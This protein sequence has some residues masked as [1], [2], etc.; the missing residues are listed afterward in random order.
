MSSNSK[1]DNVLN[2]ARPFG[3]IT[4]WG[5]PQHAGE[6]APGIW[7]IVTD[8]HG[9]VYLTPERFAQMP[10]LL[11]H[12]AFPGG[13]WFE[14]DDA[15]KAVH[16]AFPELDLTWTRYPL[17]DIDDALPADEQLDICCC[18]GTWYISHCRDG[19]GCNGCYSVETWTTSQAAASALETGKWTLRK[20]PVDP[21]S[22]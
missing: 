11:Q 21:L 16:A 18:N 4:P 10:E 19:Y 12:C 9:G 7:Q 17:A 3:D 15:V 1:S 2:P 5:K 8:R 6:I 20:T 22:L 13:T 14:E